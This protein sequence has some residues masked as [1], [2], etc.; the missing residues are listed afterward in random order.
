MLAIYTYSTT[1]TRHFLDVI[2]AAHQILTAFR[3]QNC[4]LVWFKGPR[5]QLRQQLVTGHSCTACEAETSVH[6]F[7]ELLCDLRSNNQPYVHCI[8]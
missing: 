2:K 4:L 5:Y 1:L 7:P 6:G 3:Q 8:T